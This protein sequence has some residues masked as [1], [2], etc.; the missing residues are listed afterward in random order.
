MNA[1]G[2]G[3]RVDAE[4][5][6]YRDVVVGKLLG[7]LP[8]AE[9]RGVYDLVPSYPSRPAKS[10]RPA[11]CLAVCRALGGNPSLALN[12][13]VAIELFHNAFLIHDDVQDQSE[14]R[15]GAPTMHAEHGVGFAVNVGNMTNLIGLNR[16][17]NNRWLVGVSLTWRIFQETEL[18][19]R[20]ALE[21]QAIELA[22]IRDNVCDLVDDDYYRMCLKKTSWYTCIYPCRVG[23]LVARNGHVETAEFDYYGW[24]L[25]AAFQIQDDVL[26]LV[27]EYD[28]YGKEIGGD[29]WEGK[30]TLMLIDLLR[31]LSGSERRRVERFLAQTRGQRRAADV[32]WLRSR[33]IETGC[34]ERAQ[35]SARHLADAA[36]EQAL[37]LFGD[38]PHSE[39]RDF[40][41]ALPSY[42][43]ERDR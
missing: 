33:M 41:L 39:S 13:A 21:G 15:R 9:P 36:G 4:L 20:H 1:P 6:A 26:N 3:S 31:I 22:W 11:L 23:A 43:I 42:M 16:L 2:A 38:V 25:G 18:M 8:E 10:L 29:L 7:E 24:F 27:G 14:Q 28:V 17:F 32:E 19:M 5:G 12:S 37:Q 40:L 30:R 34:I 35:E